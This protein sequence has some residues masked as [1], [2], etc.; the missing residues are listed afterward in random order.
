MTLAYKYLKKAHYD[1]KLLNPIEIEKQAAQI[2]QNYQDEQTAYI[3]EDSS[4][5]IISPDDIW[6]MDRFIGR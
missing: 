5:I 2:E 1:N 4:A 3:F 6:L